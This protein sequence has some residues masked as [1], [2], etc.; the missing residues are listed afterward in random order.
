MICPHGYTPNTQRGMTFWSW[1]YVL[2]TLGLML[3]IGIK[4]VPVYMNNY[5]IRSSL[6]WASKQPE[7]E[8]A[9]AHAI[10]SRIQRR[11]DSGYVRN[12]NGRDIKV[13]RTQDGRLLE[14]K[15]EVHKPLFF[16]IQLLF[17]FDETA[18]IPKKIE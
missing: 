11:F 8:S 18:L 16:N 4:S 12:I 6:V 17:E 14:V 1:L 9:S 2:G 3:L 13:K 5:D 10:Q 7:L 15:Y